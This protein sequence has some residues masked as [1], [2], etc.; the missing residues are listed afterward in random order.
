MRAKRCLGDPPPHMSSMT[1]ML[2]S[3]IV[4]WWPGAVFL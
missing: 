2:D 3:K 4:K 1:I